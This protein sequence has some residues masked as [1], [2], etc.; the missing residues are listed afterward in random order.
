MTDAEFKKL[1]W[2]SANKL[3]GSVSAAEYKYPVLGL[4][5]LKYVSSIFEAQRSAIECSVSEP[6]SPLYMPEDV[7]EEALAMMVEDKDAYAQDNVFWIPPKARFDHLLKQASSPKLPQLLDAAMA[8]IERENARLRGVLY[9]DFARLPLEAG[10][11]GN[12]METVAKMRFKPEDHGSRDVFG[13]VYEYFLGEFALAEGQKAGQFY[14]PRSVVRVLVE[15]LAPYEG[16]IYDPAC[17]S[18]GMFV[19]SERFIETHG[20]RRGQ[21]AVYGQEL[22]AETRKLACMNLAIRG[23]DYDLGK[24]YGDTFHNDQHPDLRADYVLANPPFNI[25]QWGADKLPKDARWKYGVPPDGNAN[26]AWLQHMT[27]RLSTD[28]RAAIVLANGSMT[29]MTNGEGDI[30]ASMIKNDLVEC[31]VAL[32]GQLFAN[33]QIPACLWF[34]SKNKGQGKCGGNDRRKQVLFIDVRKLGC[35]MLDSR[36]QKQFSNEDIQTIANTYHNWRGTQWGGGDYED[37]PGFCRSVSL[38][39]IE[40]HNHV[41]APGRHVDTEVRNDDDTP[42]EE[43]F[44][45]L[46]ETLAEQFSESEELNVLIQSKLELIVNP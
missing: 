29:T 45:A 32:P 36:K 9:R 19:Y 43:Q 40:A 16:R 35:L 3:R 38:E 7:R 34:L 15:I 11:L 28:G 23:I 1:L 12:L 33:T 26:Y 18:G 13:E 39:E 21:V 5:F 14:T 8:A 44:A 41:L 42:F 10:K 46:K 31:M 27:A 17:G 4:V 30:R 37:M 20:G 6:D 25:K 2:D 22:S 24:S